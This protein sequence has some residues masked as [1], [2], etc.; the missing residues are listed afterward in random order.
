M[1][2][3][4]TRRK[5]ADV[6]GR[7]GSAVE[8]GLGTA[9]EKAGRGVEIATS[10]AGRGIAVA[11]VQAARGV[12][13]ARPR[14]ERA[15]EATSRRL[16]EARARGGEQLAARRARAG[17][18]LAKTRRSVGFWIAGEKPKSRTRRMA[19][20]AAAV[21]AGAAAAFFL[22][23]VS[24]RRRRRLARDWTV[25]RARRLGR[26]TGEAGRAVAARASGTVQSI[27]HRGD[28][29]FPENDQVLAHK[30]ESELF[31]DIDIPSGQIVINAENGVV[32]LRGQVERP[33]DIQRV[34]REVR[35]IDG[36]REVE[37]LLHLP[38]EPAPTRR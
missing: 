36:V 16:A 19:A 30:V 28:G 17:K 27:R 7:T 4:Q 26:A 11:R 31:Q 18:R 14:L 24:G 3:K 13:R 32:V 25:A 22:D 8:Q 33:D 34:E 23:P 21:G 9:R 2:V 12:E 15:G 20:G 1:A 35:R 38:G 5:A 10:G 37:N 29:R 6:L